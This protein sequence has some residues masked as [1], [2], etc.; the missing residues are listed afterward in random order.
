MKGSEYGERELREGL[1]VD[2]TGGQKVSPWTP[3]RFASPSGFQRVDHCWSGPPGTG[4]RIEFR[5]G[6]GRRALGHSPVLRNSNILSDFMKPKRSPFFVH[7]I[8]RFDSLRLTKGFGRSHRDPQP[9]LRIPLHPLI[10]I[11]VKGVLNLQLGNPSPTQEKARSATR[12]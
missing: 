1:P 8:Y 3:G 11:V 5:I 6:E 4:T 7:D 10:M 9:T 12:T 2:K